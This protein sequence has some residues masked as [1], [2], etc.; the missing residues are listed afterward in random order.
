MGKFKKITQDVRYCLNVEDIFIELRQSVVS[1]GYGI[2]RKIWQL[3]LACPCCNNHVFEEFYTLSDAKKFG[4]ASY[5][6][7]T[8]KDEY[9][10]LKWIKNK[11]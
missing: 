8:G 2:Y 11:P 9:F 4:E 10:R 6:A 3:K 7:R 5:K 1:K